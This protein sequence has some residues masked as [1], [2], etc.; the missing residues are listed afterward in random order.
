MTTISI[1]HIALDLSNDLLEK[2]LLWSPP[3]AAPSDVLKSR[4]PVQNESA[5]KLRHFEVEKELSSISKT[6]VGRQKVKAVFEPLVSAT[7]KDQKSA[8][9]RARSEQ[10]IGKLTDSILERFPLTEPGV[11]LFVGTQANPLT[12]S[13]CANVATALAQR[14]IGEILLIDSSGK[15]EMTASNGASEQ[16]GLSNLLCQEVDWKSSLRK[17]PTSGLDFLPAGTSHWEH[18]G[19]EQKLR[20]IAAEFKKHYQF[21]CVAA[22]DPQD[23]NTKIWSGICD[24]SFLL[25]SL[26]NA[27]PAI[28]ESA[29]V[30][31]QTSG[32][33]LVG[34]VVTDA[35]GASG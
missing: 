16:R 14:K 10:P 17:M 22:D 15:K 30:E 24:G 1:P 32:A 2:K 20:R 7:R 28:A 12:S 13:T 34:C 23:S 3:L 27:N 8:I 31:L 11:I 29:V 4:G 26:K 25:V 6:N 35:D 5:F 19:A 18:W 21:V 33:R 9:G